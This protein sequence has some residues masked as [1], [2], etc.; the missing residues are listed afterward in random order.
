MNQKNLF[1]RSALAVAVAIISSNAGAAG[2]QLNEFS[3]SALGRAFSGEGVVADN[4][5]V[6]SRNPAAMTLFDRPS[7]SIGAVYINPDVDITGKS[8]MTGKSTNAKNIAPT[9]WI[10]NLHF[11]MPIDDQWFVGTSVTTNFGLA[12]DFS[13][14]YEAGP[15]GGKTDLT[16]LNFN[17]SGAYRLNDNFSFGLGLNAVYADAKI[18]RHAGILSNKLNGLIKP[19]DEVANLSGKDWGYGWNAGIMYEVDENNRYSL[20]YRSKVKVKFKDGD[21]KNDI[22]VAI[23]NRIGLPATGG[24]TIGGKLDLNLPDIWE[25]SGYNRVAP[26]WAI[27]YSLA[28]TGWSEF[29]ELKG[30]RNKDGSVLFSKHEGFKDA[31]RIA[32]GTTYYHDDNWTF[33]T[34]IAFDDS[35]IPAENRSISIP[36]QDRFWLSAG[37]TYAFNKDMSVDVG[38]SYMHGQ[39]VTVKEKLSEKPDPTNKPYE[40]DAKGSAWLYGVNFNYAF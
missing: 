4:A 33:R 20:T 26:K 32:L 36:D 9:A 12:T 10:P 3:T 35:P 18:V 37:A 31:Y 14:N 21:Y 8:P 28:Y 13:N 1:T 34:G 39:K 22:P 23:G 25:V 19:T 27:H 24:Q 40:F 11:I 30:T 2:F 29:S 7:F 15:I 5:T 38:V 17:L 16:T 6:G